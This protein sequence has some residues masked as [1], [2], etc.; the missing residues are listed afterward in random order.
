M[1]N[2]TGEQQHL[3]LSHLKLGLA[4]HG[5]VMSRNHFLSPDSNGVAP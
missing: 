5:D 1:Q 3:L 2:N 4:I